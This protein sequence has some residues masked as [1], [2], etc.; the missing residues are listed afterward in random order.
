MNR[1]FK[2]STLL[3]VTCV[4]ALLAAQP[5]T[6]RSANTT[7]YVSF[8]SG[9]DSN[10]GQM[11][12][13]A[14][15]TI[16]K[17]NSLALGAGDRVL[18]KCGDT[19]RAE[20]LRVTTSGADGNPIT[21][22]SYPTTDCA[23][24]PILSGAQPITAWTVY[25]GN[26][27]VA[28]LASPA[29][30]A[31]F[32]LATTSGINQLFRNGQRLGI[33]RWPNI[34]AT[35]GGYSTIDAQPSD[36]QITDNQLP[37]ENW[38]GAT[39]HIKGMRWYILNRDVIGDI[40]NTL[41]VSSTL[42]CW[43]GNC[44]GW[45][46]WLDS[47]IKTLDRDGEWYYNAAANKVYLY[48]T[49]GSPN[50]A[51]IEGSVVL[52]GESAYLGGVILGEHLWRHVAH[53]VIE[54]FE[55]SRWFDNGITT[56]VNL[57][58]DENSDIVIR[59]NVIRDVDS[60]GIN[61]ATWVWNVAA[62]G[63]RGGHDIQIMGNVIDTAN[64]MGIN[65][66]A[67][68][69]LF[70][71]NVIRNVA[72]IQNLGKAGMG[73]ATDAGGGLCTEDGDGIRIKVDSD[74]TY[75]GN[76]VTMRY[77]RLE[78]IGYNGVDVFG[79]NNTF[80]SNVV[81]NACYSK[82]DCGGLRSFGR[83]NLA[84]TTARNLAVTNNMI[85]DTLGNTDGA[86]STYDPLFGFGLYI[87]N[88]STDVVASGNTVISSTVSGILYQNSTGT[89]QN[90]TLY[91]N[92]AGTLWAHQVDIGS[93][94]SQVASFT[95][96]IMLGLK[97]TAGTLQVDS[98]AQLAASDYNKF[99]HANRATHISA[100]GDKTLAQ[101]KAYSGK[102]AHSTEMIS[103]TLTNSEIFY[104][105]AKTLKTIYLTRPYVDLDGQPVAANL[106]LQPF[107]SKILIPG[108]PPVPNLTLAGSA[109]GWIHSGEQFTYTL[110]AANRGG[111]GATNL[112]VTSTIPTGANYVSGGTRMGNV[113][114]W[115]VPSLLPNNAVTFTFS[116]T[117][118]DGVKV[119]INGDYRTSADGG[120]GAV[121]TSVVTL[122]DPKQ[123]YLP[124]VMR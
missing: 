72:L 119:I 19:W 103:S 123:V 1:S 42:D 121:G 20:M 56:P 70:Q 12:S 58:K 97:S 120:Y 124:I 9:S 68:Q 37:N 93:S 31:N 117:P 49:G 16:G 100:A 87:D 21:F 84:S 66:Y 64:A 116:V 29:N 41:V 32:P 17:V 22:S 91:N 7:Y 6:V 112:V 30:A 101:W 79:Y 44:T 73:C 83:D 114:S 15:K 98:H 109:P 23:D 74:G 106:T 13:A 18:F 76:N 65:S 107:T 99:A 34:D 118:T 8:S 51:L 47:H 27:Y 2:L 35:D 111:I 89:I 63:W 45:G 92:S 81:V 94:P 88:Y 11:P 60:V 75:S 82:G 102:D 33:G 122:V 26:I 108:G 77:N 71:D 55:I 95:G 67:R 104:N 28:D 62:Y 3:A 36:T 115:T 25:S 10:D 96:N 80:D 61:L 46:F 57:E 50:N 52:K 38:T 54:N 105:D 40:G 4:I 48:S 110:A 78:R 24:K 113:I 43:G 86:H 14:F 59:N 39:A 69:S 85:V 5:V 90:N 53:I